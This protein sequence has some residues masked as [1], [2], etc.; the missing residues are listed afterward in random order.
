MYDS[1]AKIAY[2]CI[3][4]SIVFPVLSLAKRTPAEWAALAS[5]DDVWKGI[6]NDWKAGD[7][8]P[9]LESDEDLLRKEM[10]KRKQNSEIDINTLEGKDP[11][12]AMAAMAQPHNSGP[13]IIFITMPDECLIED[14]WCREEG[15]NIWQ[16][17]DTERMGWQ[18]KEQLSLGGVDVTP[19]AI[20]ADQL[21][22][23]LQRGWRGDQLKDFLLDQPQVVQIR[24]NDVDYPNSNYK[25][26]PK[27]NKK[28][29]KKKKSKVKRKKKKNRKRK[30]KKTKQAKVVSG[31]SPSHSEF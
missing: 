2:I 29:S 19:Y 21:L 12:A 7:S 4:L 18:W 25:G 22:L 6:E 10:D 9:E 23:T 13:T 5:D 24:W 28:E 30:S 27:K 16:K 8:A 17:D 15:G 31:H 1:T 14:D 26:K 3:L 20:E 11:R